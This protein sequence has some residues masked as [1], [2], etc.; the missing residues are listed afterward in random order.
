MKIKR[1]MYFAL[2]VGLFG[3]LL[4]G[5]VSIRGIK[6]VGTAWALLPPIIAIVLAL[7][8]KEVYSS[9]FMGILSGAMLASGGS[10]TRAMDHIVNDGF[11]K[12]ISG[13]AGIFMFLVI[14]GILVALINKSG[15]TAAFG[16]TMAE[17]I[18]TRKHAQV[19]TFFLGIMIFIDDYFNCLTV[20]SVM[21]PICDENR[22]SRTKLAY[23]I[24][25][26]AAPIC[27]IAPISSW[28]AA[29]S[30]YVS[31]TGLS[32]IELF[33]RSIPY[34]FYSILT[35]VFALSMILMDVDFG[36][37]AE[38]ERRAIKNGDLSEGGDTTNA[39]QVN[40][41]G[42][43][44]DLVFPIVTLIIV[45]VFALIYVGGFYE[46]GGEF[47]HNFVGA[48][49]N[50]DA[51][52]GLPWGALITLIIS[53]IYFSLRGVISF[54]KMMESL[55]EG[56][57]AMVPAII[58]LTMATSLKNISNDLLGSA[59]YVRG[60][61]EGNAENL[62]SLLPAVIYV[63]AVLL[64]F[65]TGTSWGTFGILIPIVSSMFSYTD[66]IFIIGISACLSGAVCGDHLSPISD[67]TIMSSAGAGCAHVDHVTT[68]LPYGIAVAAISAGAFIISGFVHSAIVGLG[69][70]ILATLGVISFIKNKN[71]NKNINRIE[72]KANVNN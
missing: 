27:M 34:N 63:V 16:R 38:F 8:T 70:G 23:I 66:P 43:V 3:F 49:G 6:T 4:S 14:L 67:T 18:K 5:Y 17:K 54:E 68:Q 36:P 71:T 24:D 58:I 9:L 35:I 20:G 30:G 57:N 1:N 22:V 60:L 7:V 64:A 56:F 13:T 11:I 37:M 21:R 46:V 61:M 59:E 28:A 10:L 48:F 31:G 12:S 53:V 51:T 45:S 25:A 44:L 40:P 62:Y 50:T 42:R 15:G 29:V 55:P 26:T 52:V 72:E 69:F 32:G 33:I 19:A 47:Y 2:I 65:A 41:R 39:K